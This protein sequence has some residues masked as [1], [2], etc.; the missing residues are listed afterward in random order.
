MLQIFFWYFNIENSCV[1]V[2]RTKSKSK[3]KLKIIFGIP[4]KRVDYYST[5]CYNI[6]SGWGH[7]NKIW[8]VLT[9]TKPQH[10]SPPKRRRR[11]TLKN[12]RKPTRL[13]C[14]GLTNTSTQNSKAPD[15]VRSLAVLCM[16][17]EYF[18]IGNF[19]SLIYENFQNF[20]INNFKT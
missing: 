12:A 10:R 4:Q 15:I 19:K 7:K 16:F 11:N 13:S 14:T 20:N 1:C 6:D 9:W 3:S 5:M 8:E 17:F 2:Y 18:N